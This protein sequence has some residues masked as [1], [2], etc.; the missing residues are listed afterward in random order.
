MI[1][2]DIIGIIKLILIRNIFRNMETCML[3]S[4]SNCDVFSFGQ[5]KVYFFNNLYINMEIHD[6]E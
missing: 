2:E 5:A 3:C 6:F 1:V 4:F